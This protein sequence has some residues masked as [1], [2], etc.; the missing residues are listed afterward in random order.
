M[1]MTSIDW[2]A[3]DVGC[4]FEATRIVG[5][6]SGINEVNQPF[7]KCF[8]YV[9]KLDNTDYVENAESPWETDDQGTASKKFTTGEVY[10]LY[11]AGRKLSAS[12]KQEISKN[13]GR[14]LLKFK[15]S[16]Q[17]PQDSDFKV[18]QKG[19]SLKATA[20]FSLPLWIV[21]LQRLEAE[22]STVSTPKPQAVLSKV[23]QLYYEAPSIL[24]HWYH[25]ISTDID[26]IFKWSRINETTG[27]I[28]M[29]DTTV[30]L[31]TCE[32]LSFKHSRTNLTYHLKNKD[33]HIEE[34]FDFVRLRKQRA[35][36]Q[37]GHVLTGFESEI[38]AP[39]ILVRSYG[40]E[41]GVSAATWAGDL[42]QAAA[43]AEREHKKK[44]NSGSPTEKEW[45]D[46]RDK[47]ASVYEMLGD[48][49]GAAHSIRF[50]S[51]IEKREATLSHE[52]AKLLYDSEL[53]ANSGKLFVERYGLNLEKIPVDREST[54]TIIREVDKFVKIWE[55]RDN[56]T[57]PDSA[58]P[59]LSL[60]SKG[61]VVQYLV[62]L[63]RSL[64]PGYP[65]LSPITPEL[66]DK[67][68]DGLTMA[69]EA[70][71]G[72]DGNNPDSD[73]DGLWDG[74]EVRKRLPVAG[75][76]LKDADPLIPDLYVQVDYFNSLGATSEQRQRLRDALDVIVKSFAKPREGLPQGIRLH[77]EW[78]KQG[79]PDVNPLDVIKKSDGTNTWRDLIIT[80]FPVVKQ[81]THRHALLALKL[82]KG[83][84]HAL[85]QAFVIDASPLLDSTMNA[86]RANRIVAARFMRELGRTL[87]LSAG[88]M[89]KN[90]SRVV[91]D[92]TPFKPNHVSI[93]NEIWEE[94]IRREKPSG[95]FEWVFDYQDFDIPQSLDDLSLN[96]AD[97]IGLK[98]VTPIT[99]G[100]FTINRGRKNLGDLKYLPITGPIDWNHNNNYD[101][102]LIVE[103]LSGRMTNTKFHSTIREW[104]NLKYSSGWIG[105]KSLYYSEVL[106]LVPPA[107][108]K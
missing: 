95:G 13:N 53:L 30:K 99:R 41:K 71:F 5:M 14:M 65:P 84:G 8:I 102:G 39:S 40:Y 68:F 37:I 78:Q 1:A 98:L 12:E 96:E 85:N 63:L 32:A 67:D 86:D 50:K 97:G 9:F 49:I 92:G 6:T 105:S 90:G 26:P 59:A 74:W 62:E 45:L 87:G 38:T 17:Q 36:I 82:N 106:K 42:G 103:S 23:R 91:R 47:T 55:R 61:R 100:F 107:T 58:L 48:I 16:I 21:Y 77:L 20:E 43:T 80:S 104:N 25:L 66:M 56:W 24:S 10:Y 31:D 52:L 101:S 18:V 35:I 54:N 89:Y 44:G 79:L 70:T 19:S 51:A 76:E 93:M 69:E 4:L 3:A 27:V 29:W 2:Q 108:D 72:T 46:A 83:L 81:L 57:G 64:N 73:G 33:R 75:I 11:F 22:L 28:T 88:G 7:K 94:G 15:A 60:T 34:R